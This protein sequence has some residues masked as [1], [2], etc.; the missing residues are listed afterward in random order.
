M[1]IYILISSATSL[2]VAKVTV[3]RTRILSQTPAAHSDCQ[4]RTPGHPYQNP[5]QPLPPCGKSIVETVGLI[6][7]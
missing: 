6:I 5:P 2:A 7:K 4:T 3:E 1:R